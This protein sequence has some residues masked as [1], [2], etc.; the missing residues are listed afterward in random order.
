[1]YLKIELVLGMLRRTRYWQTAMRCTR[2]APGMPRLRHQNASLLLHSVKL[3]EFPQSVHTVRKV[4]LHVFATTSNYVKHT[5]FVS[6]KKVV[7][8]FRTLQRNSM[9]ETYLASLQKT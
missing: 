6:K 8:T 7:D 3:D 9:A 1:M 5:D 4:I 2:D